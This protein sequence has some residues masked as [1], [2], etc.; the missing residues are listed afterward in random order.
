M[1]A[2]DPWPQF[3][4]LRLE[5]DQRGGEEDDGA[6]AVRQKVGKRDEGDR[7]TDG[8]H[9]VD[10][11][12]RQEGVEARDLHRRRDQHAV[13]RP[14]I[15]G[16]RLRPVAVGKMF[17]GAQ[18]E[19]RIGVG[20]PGC[21]GAPERQQE[22]EQRRH[23]ETAQQITLRDAGHATPLLRRKTCS[24]WRQ[25][26]DG[27]SGKHYPYPAIGPPSTGASIAVGRGSLCGR[28]E[29]ESDSRWRSVHAR[30]GTERRQVKLDTA[31]ETS[32]VRSRLTCRRPPRR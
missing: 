15:D 27:L 13:E 9:G 2:D 3:G 1:I 31:E 23:G 6:V 12:R 22:T 24:S 19:D 11:L 18:V 16:Q 17:G 25:P 5:H 7:H 30:H 20:N 10:D 26:S 8:E 28:G 32:A 21:E 29:N 14:A 4:E